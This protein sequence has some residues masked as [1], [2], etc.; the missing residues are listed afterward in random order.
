MVKKIMANL[1]GVSLVLAGRKDFELSMSTN[2]QMSIQFRAQKI[3][4]FG[5]GKVEA[6]KVEAGKVEA[7]LTTYLCRQ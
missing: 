4:N 5:A 7:G 3:N 2:V 6:G 1:D